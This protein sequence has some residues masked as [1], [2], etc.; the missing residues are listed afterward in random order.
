MRHVQVF[1]YTESHNILP[2]AQHDAKRQCLETTLLNY[3]AVS[4]V[5]QTP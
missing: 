1:S 5:Q 3:E 2:L 4:E